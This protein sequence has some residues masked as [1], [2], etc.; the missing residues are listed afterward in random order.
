MCV[1]CVAV[2]KKILFGFGFIVCKAKILLPSKA[3]RH[4]TN[5]IIGEGD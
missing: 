4:E 1:V 5:N 2:R 3:A